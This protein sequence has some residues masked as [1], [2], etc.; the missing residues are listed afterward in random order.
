[1]VEDQLELVRGRFERH[2]GPLRHLLARDQRHLLEIRR[3]VEHERLAQVEPRQIVDPHVGGLLAVLVPVPDRVP[4]ERERIPVAEG[5]AQHDVEFLRL[6]GRLRRLG[7]TPRDPR[8]GGLLSLDLVLQR[9]LH[10]ALQI[11]ALITPHI[12]VDPVFA[13]DQHDR[14][15]SLFLHDRGL[16]EVRGNIERAFALQERPRRSVDVDAHSGDL[17]KILP[18]LVRD[19]VPL[20]DEMAVL[21]DVPVDGDRD[22]AV[23][24]GL[25]RDG[26]RARGIVVGGSAGAG[27]AALLGLPLHAL[28]LPVGTGQPLAQHFELLFR[29]AGRPFERFD[30]RIKFRTGLHLAFERS[31][32]RGFRRSLGRRRFR[33]LPRRVDRDMVD[34]DG[35]VHV[36]DHQRE[37]VRA[38]DQL[39]TVPPLFL[40]DRGP[41]EIRRESELERLLQ[42]V[43]RPAVDRDAGRLLERLVPELDRVPAEDESVAAVDHARQFDRALLGLR[44][45][46]PG[47]RWFRPGLRCCGEWHDRRE[48]D[49][50]EDCALQLARESCFHGSLLGV[51][52]GAE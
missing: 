52:G 20:E 30:K 13:R 21:P 36:V 5:S 16:L 27:G 29:R 42:V 11:Q 49:E 51:A 23:F 15:L 7:Q 46:R 10:V 37:G 6:V 12:Q 47:C 48:Q 18:R 35:T 14:F 17:H 40:H 4:L 43:P 25:G 31:G 8:R 32:R 33:S 1:M 24:V 38:G 22:L 28:D 19:R 26:R 41:L 3:E 50:A 2:R 9:D 34:A 45:F 44:G 39:H